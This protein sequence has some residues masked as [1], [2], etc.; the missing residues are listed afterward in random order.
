M[1]ID[2]RRDYFDSDTTLST[3]TIPGL[4]V[5]HFLE[6]ALRRKKVRGITGFASGTFPLKIY[7]VATPMTLRFR[8]YPWFEFFIE[9]D[10]IPEFDLCYLH[11]GNYSGDTEGCPLTGKKRYKHP[12]NGWMVTNSVDAMK[13]IYEYLYPKLDSGELI[14]WKVTQTKEYFADA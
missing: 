6:D 14:Y 9:V 13:E 5:Y 1:I 10:H 2:V 12:T 4:G 8:K 3:V 11:S 7:K